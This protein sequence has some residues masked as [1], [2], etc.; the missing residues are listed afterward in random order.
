MLRFS[1]RA[2]FRST[3]MLREQETWRD[4]GISYV[5]Y[6]TVC[7][8]ALHKAVKESKQSKYVKFS[9]VG[10]HAQEPDGNGTFQKVTK[11][12]ATL[13]E[14]ADIKPKTVTGGH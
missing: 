5:Q 7:T 13:T 11:V 6:L 12:P 10:Y 2:L 3:R 1:P 4:Q 9:E 8:A 14:F